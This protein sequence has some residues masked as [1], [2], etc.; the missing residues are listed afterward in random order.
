MSTTAGRSRVRPNRKGTRSY[1]S[2]SQPAKRVTE[3]LVDI[4]I[5]PSDVSLPPKVMVYVH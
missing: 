2:V 5:L 3:K 1:G 4:V